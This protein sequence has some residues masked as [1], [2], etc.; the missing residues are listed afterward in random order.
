M[1]LQIVRRVRVGAT[2]HAPLSIFHDNASSIFI[3]TM[4]GGF[5]STRSIYSIIWVCF[6]QVLKKNVMYSSDLQTFLE[7]E[8]PPSA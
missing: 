4:S 2:H 1:C 3:S 5:I 6:W 8:L 7:S